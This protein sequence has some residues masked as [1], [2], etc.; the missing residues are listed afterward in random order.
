MAIPHVTVV[1]GGLGGLVAAISVAESG[2]QVTLHESHQSLGGRWRAAPSPRLAHD[3][4]HVLYADG[5]LYAWLQARDLLGPTTGV[6]TRGLARFWFRVGGRLRRIPPAGLARVMLARGRAA[7]VEAS[8]ADWATSSFGAE[9]AR[10]AASATGVALFHHD[11]G[12]LSAAFVWDRFRRALA[13][14]PAARFRIGGWA[15]LL[16]ALG[17]HAR[18]LGVVIELGSRLDRLPDTGVSI[19]ATELEAAR[20]LLGDDSLDW[21]SGEV[22]LLDLAV[23]RARGDAYLIS[24]L[25]EA[26]WFEDFATPDPTMAP[27]GEVLG[28]LQLGL[29]PNESRVSARLR[30]ERL[31]DLAMPNWQDRVTWRRDAVAS[32]RTGALDHP[33]RT[34]R[35]R[36]AVDRGDGVFLVGDRVAAPGLLSEVSWASA[37]QAAGAAVGEPSVRP[38]RTGSRGPV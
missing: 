14:T 36:P 15:Q 21:P 37:V 26:G 35:D 16:P 17:E 30:L 13:F 5:P 31:A 10:L 18:A 25:D 6:P 34:W 20:S 22:A 3:G 32:G 33:G 29:R 4:P 9:T 28:Q 8:F 24:D 2:A 23:T 11:P 27:V 7:P 1:G 12:E 19:V 38:T